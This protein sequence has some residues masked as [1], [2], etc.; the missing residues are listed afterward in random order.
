MAKIDGNWMPCYVKMDD[1]TLV[2]CL[3]LEQN[4]DDVYKTVGKRQS[5]SGFVVGEQGFILTNKH[6]AA[7][8]ASRYEDFR[9][10]D[11]A[12]G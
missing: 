8:W 10:V 5:G 2:R 7:G 6:V 11:G 1:G 9:F 12:T 3:T 4:K